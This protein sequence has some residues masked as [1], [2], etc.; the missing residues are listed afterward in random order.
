MRREVTRPMMAK[1]SGLQSL[2]FLPP[3]R[4]SACAVRFY[5][6]I[7]EVDPLLRKLLMQSALLLMGC[8]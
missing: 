8:R 6:H 1:L 2:A 5:P 3:T 4:Y 7:S